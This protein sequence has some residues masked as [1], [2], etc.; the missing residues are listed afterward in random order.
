MDLRNEADESRLEWAKGFRKFGKVP[1]RG[2]AV[3]TESARLYAVENFDIGVT[4]KRYN[5]LYE[6]CVSAVT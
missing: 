1:V 3:R 6:A 5:D 2:E 4:A